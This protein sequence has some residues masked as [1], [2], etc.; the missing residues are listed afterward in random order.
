MTARHAGRHVL[1]ERIRGIDVERGAAR[2]LNRVFGFK[3][4]E[5]FEERLPDIGNGHLTSDS[6]FH[7]N[8]LKILIA[9]ITLYFKYTTLSQAIQIARG[10]KFCI[11]ALIGSA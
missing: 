9:Y 8:S 7:G 3:F 4:M 11:A 2:E 6:D 1:A 5:L 10:R